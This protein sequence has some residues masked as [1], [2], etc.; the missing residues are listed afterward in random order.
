MTSFCEDWCVL[1]GTRLCVATRQ[2]VVCVDEWSSDVLDSKANTV[3]PVIYART[4][5]PTRTSRATPGASMGSLP[6]RQDSNTTASLR[7]DSATTASLCKDPTTAV[8][9]DSKKHRDP[10][11]I[12]LSSSDPSPCSALMHT[13]RQQ[14]HP[15]S[16]GGYGLR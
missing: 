11:C 4:T 1:L 9:L 3:G 10:S 12:S 14:R 15:P 2:R 16:R 13:A 8:R 5:A 6:S 7:K